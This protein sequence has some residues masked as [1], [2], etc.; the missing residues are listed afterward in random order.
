MSLESLDTV[1]GHKV[2]DWRLNRYPCDNSAL[3]EIFDYNIIK[4]EDKAIDLRYLRKAQFEA[5]ETYWY[6][7]LVEKT[8]LVIGLYQ[9]FFNDDLSLLKALGMSF[10]EEWIPLLS[11]NGVRSILEKVKLDK[12]FVS[13]YRL[14]NVYETISLNYPS[15]IFALAMGAGKTTL[16]GSI[17]AMEFCLAMEYPKSNDFIKN[18]LVFA[19]GKT[20]LG[21]L[22][23]LAEVP[24]EKIIPP[25]MYREFLSSIKMTYTKDG[26]KDIPIAKGSKYNI[27]VTNTEK[28]RIQKPTSRSGQFMLFDFKG[29]ENY[30]EQNEIANLRLQSI[31]S[32]PNLGIFSDEAHH[33]YGQSLDNELKKVRKTVDYLAEN[34]TVISVINTTGTPYYRKRILKD[35]VYWY[36]LSE[37]IK[38]GIL[39]EV[40]NNIVSYQDTTSEEFLK[41]IVQDFFQDYRDI[42]IY[43]GS[44]SKLAIYFPQTKDLEMGRP[45][46][47]KILRSI[48]IDSNVILEVNNKSTLEVKD[49]FNNRINDP[50]LPYRVFLLVNMGTEG[51]NCPSLFATA[52]ARKLPSS[53]NFVLQ[54]ATRC[55]RQIPSNLHKAKIYLSNE[56]VKILDSQ[57][58]ETYGQSLSHLNSIK[59]S[60]VKD[61]ILVRKN[62]ILPLTIRK[63][64]R[65]VT[66]KEP[67]KKLLL[68]RPSVEAKKSL[69]IRYDLKQ[70]ESG[71]LSEKSRHQL[72]MTGD[73]I[74]IYSA[75]LELASI[76]RLDT[77]EICNQLREL[78]PE[79]EI[80]EHELV[81]LKHQIEQDYQ[82]YEITY[83]EIS[84]NLQLI[85][86]EGFDKEI[87]DGKIIYSSEITY[88]KGEDRLLSFYDQHKNLNLKDIGFHYTPYKFDSQPEK[89]M[90]LKLLD[91][92]NEDLDNIDDILFTGGITDP[93]KTDLLFEY[94]DKKEK[95]RSY[96]PDFLIRKKDGRCLLVEIKAAPFMDEFKEMAIKKIADLNKELIQYKRVDASQ[97]L[98]YTDFYFVSDWI[99]EKV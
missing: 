64:I 80:P 97:G 29:R 8:P 6:L 67:D 98:D 11:N 50:H 69:E 51:W 71:L 12:S 3:A 28:I 17:I 46:V 63:L 35:V 22:K 85:K 81:Y 73:S 41:V 78:Y 55:L 95:W 47:Q 53:N 25:R 38:D 16:I 66:Y 91:M 44:P 31:A 45:V 49:L 5:L 70:D 58:Q 57:L 42:S 65:R 19:P 23:E 72:L 60:K 77:L 79:Q 68:T 54:A 14:E 18:A 62:E 10:Q 33:T 36:G 92:L 84:D 99:Y 88:D 9:K 21:A 27:I 1:I 83:E 74:D 7:R 61:K 13:R 43:D 4:A 40:R 96:T 48:G 30:E 59:Q 20:I 34:T 24:Y 32:L 2:L 39:K 15:Y 82:N 90:F 75:S 86:I 76:Y 26:E 93:K 56:N 94:K 87:L 89:E 37:G 52:L